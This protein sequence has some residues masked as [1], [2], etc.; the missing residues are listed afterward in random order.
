MGVFFVIEINAKAIKQNVTMHFFYDVKNIV[1]SHLPQKLMH[2]FP[3]YIML[4]VNYVL[5]IKNEFLCLKIFCHESKQ[6]C[7]NGYEFLLK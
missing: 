3:L 7:L 1:R 2:K 4:N 6:Q 5:G